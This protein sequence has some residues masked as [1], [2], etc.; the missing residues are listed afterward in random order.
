MSLGISGAWAGE[1]LVPG[2]G[3]GLSGVLVLIV[4]QPVPVFLGNMNGPLKVAPASSRI[5]SPSCAISIASWRSSP[6]PMRIVRPDEGTNVVSTYSRGASG[7]AVSCR[8]P[9]GAPAH[10]NAGVSNDTRSMA[11]ATNG[12]IVDSSSGRS[13]MPGVAYSP[14]DP[15][16]AGICR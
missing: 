3:N 5:V 6:S 8:T 11:A 15:L 14:P 9:D 7:A 16:I 10:P 2:A 1:T 4:T 13:F 12:Y